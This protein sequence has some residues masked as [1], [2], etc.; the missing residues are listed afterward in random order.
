M[1]FLVPFG[2]YPQGGLISTNPSLGRVLYVSSTYGKSGNSGSDVEPMATIVAAMAKL[3]NANNS[4]NRGDTIVCLP[5]HTEDVPD[6]T[7]FVASRPKLT[8]IGLGYGATQATIT[9]STATTATLNVT[10]ANVSF[11]NIRV[12]SNIAACAAVFTVAAKDFQFQ[13]GQIVEGTGTIVTFVITSAATSNL[14]D[15]LSITGSYLVA[16]AAANGLGISITGTNDRVN[17]SNNLIRM[18]INSSLSLI[19]CASGKNLTNCKIQNNDLIRLFTATTPGAISLAG[20]GN[21]G[22][23][24]L[25]RIKCAVAAIANIVSVIDATGCGLINNYATGEDDKS[26]ILVPAADAT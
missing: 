7:T 9:L 8:I 20:S 18:Q 14:V 17:I 6:A 15:G 25:N 21:T 10:G 11:Q 26:G 12:V 24:S 2:S 13:G 23:V 5:G 16:D 22:M 1:P 19:D 3:A 4:Q